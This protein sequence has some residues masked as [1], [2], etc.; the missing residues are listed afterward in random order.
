MK[1]SIPKPRFLRHFSPPQARYRYGLVT[2]KFGTANKLRC[3]ASALRSCD[4]VHCDD[5]QLN[6]LLQ[7]PLPPS[8]SDCECHQFS[9]WR[10]V[11]PFWN[12][13]DYES[14][15]RG[16][17]FLEGC[18]EKEVTIQR[19]VVDLE[20]FN[21]PGKLRRDIAKTFKSIRF[22]EE[23]VQSAGAVCDIVGG[24]PC[25][26][27]AISRLLE[28]DVHLAPARSIQSHQRAL[29]E[30]LVLASADFFHRFLYEYFY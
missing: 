9:T 19:N 27:V 29:R 30:I 26:G 21:V 13:A 12:P 17:I 28:G 20:Y 7:T 24:E 4:E 6:S 8:R 25:A 5:E 18:R 22:N 1:P 14:G 16:S 23:V 11:S 2:N 10:L 15:Y 3:L